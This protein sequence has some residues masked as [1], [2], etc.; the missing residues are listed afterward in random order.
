M[1]I[2]GVIPTRYGSTRFPGKP[3]I[4]IGGKSMIQRVYEQCLKTKI[5][6]KILVATDDERIFKHAS[7]FSD[8]IMTRSDHP[9]GTDRCREA[10]EQQQEIF[11]YV[12]NIQ[13]DEPFID[14]VQIE[15]LAAELKKG[16]SIAT[17]AKPIVDENMLQN[18]NIVKVVIASDGN[19]LYFSRAPIP[20]NRNAGNNPWTNKHTYLKHIGLYGYNADSLREITKLPVGQLERMESLEQL[21][22]LEHGYRIRVGITNIETIGIDTP[23]DLEKIKGYY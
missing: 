4:D 20:F 15:I 19:A 22:W 21:R 1:K 10:L 9:S 17:L 12:I 3:L 13:G 5:L 18:P 7:N 8:V 14:P 23:E 16:A 2:L 11:D 6:S